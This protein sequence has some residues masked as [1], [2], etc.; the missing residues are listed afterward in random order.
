V[1]IGLDDAQC[2]LLMDAELELAGLEHVGWLLVLQFL[3]AF[4]LAV[5]VA[6]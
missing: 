6:A 2:L 5:E 4:D 1:D 3:W